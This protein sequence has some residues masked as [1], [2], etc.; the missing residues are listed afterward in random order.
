[1]KI[2]GLCSP[3]TNR[4]ERAS[5]TSANPRQGTEGVRTLQLRGPQPE[6]LTHSKIKIPNGKAVAGWSSTKLHAQ[7]C[8][9]KELCVHLLLRK[10]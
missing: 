9:T 2:K 5:T 10:P 1:M 8:D 7:A 3:Q 6:K 4:E